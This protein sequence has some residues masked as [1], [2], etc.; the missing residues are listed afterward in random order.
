MP[1]IE[2]V[3]VKKLSFIPDERGRLIEILRRDDPIFEKFGQIYLT[4]AYPGVIKA[5]H[6]HRLQ[7]DYFAVLSGMAQ[8]VLYDNREGSR[9]RGLVDEFFAGD[10]NPLLISIPPQVIHG[11]KALGMKEVLLLNCPTE[12]YNHAEPDEYRLPVDTPMIPF[13]W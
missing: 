8:I 2:G 5:W 4:T 3:M 1:Q 12:P 10:Y 13:Q 7:K 6:Y 11:F 9:T